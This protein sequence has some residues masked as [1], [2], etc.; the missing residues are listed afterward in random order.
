MREL[1]QTLVAGV[2]TGQV[3]VSGIEV[4]DDETTVELDDTDDNNDDEAGMLD[5]TNV[6]DDI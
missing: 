6:E 3:Y 5:E 1:Y 2:V 4:V